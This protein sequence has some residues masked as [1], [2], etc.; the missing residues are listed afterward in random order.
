[1]FSK[2]LTI[3]INIKHIGALHHNRQLV[4]TK[5]TKKTF[6]FFNIKVDIPE[7]YDISQG[8]YQTLYLGHFRCGKMYS[9]E[10][11]RNIIKQKEKE[12]DYERKEP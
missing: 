9:L 3:Q 8:D 7:N 10:Q 6:T 11:A 2:E 5:E 12:K 1:V 4:S